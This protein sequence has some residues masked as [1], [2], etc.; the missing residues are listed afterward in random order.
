VDDTNERNRAVDKNRYEV[1]G[2]PRLALAACR[3]ATFQVTVVSSSAPAVAIADIAETEK[4]R[5]G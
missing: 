3:T 4:G 2:I 1:L 5:G